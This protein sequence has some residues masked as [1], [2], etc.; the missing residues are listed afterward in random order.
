MPSS[1]LFEGTALFCF[2]LLP[3]SCEHSSP[4]APVLLWHYLKINSTFTKRNLTHS[5]GMR[6]TD[7]E[8]SRSEWSVMW[9]FS[10]ARWLVYFIQPACFLTNHSCHVNDSSLPRLLRVSPFPP[11]ILCSESK[12]SFPKSVFRYISTSK[13]HEHLGTTQV[14]NSRDMNQNME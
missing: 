5:F 13:K 12:S 7:W 11:E 9:D 6:K 8:T 4:T 3:M 1:R 2:W 10:S 14:R